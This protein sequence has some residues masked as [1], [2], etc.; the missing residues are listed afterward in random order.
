MDSSPLDGMNFPPEDVLALYS[1]AFREFCE[2]MR[3][4]DGYWY[5]KLT[6]DEVDALVSHNRL[7]DFTNDWS[8]ESGWTPKK[9]VV[10]TAK[11]VNAWARSDRMGHDSSNHWIAVEQRL[12]RLGLPHKC[13]VCD[14][15][16]YIYT[17]PEPHLSLVLWM[18]HPRKGAARGVL[19]RHVGRS[20][21]KKA[22][23]WLA[24]AQRR[25]TERF[26]KVAAFAKQK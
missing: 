22:A 24:E 18:I 2:E 8:K 10:V 21:V 16:G 3:D 25:N 4:G 14:G 1:P 5:D 17:E 23:E 7:R 19:I 26:A 15:N 12:N 13:T 11:E 9:N 6:Q 20:D